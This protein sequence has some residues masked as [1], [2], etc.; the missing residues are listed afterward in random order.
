MI[1]G[2]LRDGRVVAV[3]L[4]VALAVV[5]LLNQFAPTRSAFSARVTNSTNTAATAPYFTCTGAVGA[6]TANALFAYRLTEASGSKTATDWSG[7]GSNGTYQGTMTATTPSPNACPRDSGSAYALNGSTS[8]VSTPRSV[9]NPTTF[10]EE[11]WFRTTVAG[12]MLIGFG[13]SQTGASS[14]HD[15]K[16]YLTTTGQLAFGTYTGSAT[17]VLTSPR[18]YT[19]GSWHHVVTTM[20]PTNGMRLSVD[21]KLVASNAAFT[22]AE[23][24]TGYFRIGYD[25]VSGWPG[26]SSNP[27]FTGSM[28]YAAVYSTELTA[29]QIAA[30]AAAG[31]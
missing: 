18:S 6:D 11:V 27:Y 8:Y 22:T 26:A 12:G 30:H 21:G 15:R 24:F 3:L 5:V 17:Q 2:R 31:S 25:V 20:S 9:A 28:R 10:S 13:S 1:L 29:S 16:L 19:D 14:Q 4:V 23:N 7:R